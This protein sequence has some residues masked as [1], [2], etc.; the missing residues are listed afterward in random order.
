MLSL[1]SSDLLWLPHL[2]LIFSNVG[3]GHWVDHILCFI[4]HLICNQIKKNVPR[5]FGKCKHSVFYYKAQ[6]LFVKSGL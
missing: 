4:C 2:F 1:V 3:S 5:V 6:N